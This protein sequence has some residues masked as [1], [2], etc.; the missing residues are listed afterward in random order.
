M[1]PWLIGLA[2]AGG[3]ARLLPHPPNVAPVA[4]LALFGGAC[5]SRLWMAVLVTL[6]SMI[7]S[8][9]VLYATV[10]RSFVESAAGIA[11][12]VLPVYGAFLLTIVVGRWLCRPRTWPRIASASVA[13][14][15]LFFVITNF[16]VWYGSRAYP[17]TWAGLWACYVAALPFLRNSL[18]GDLF[19]TV[20]LFGLAEAVSIGGR[21]GAAGSARA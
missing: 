3:L 13:A 15:L 10:Y 8:D 7:F 21:T 2:F 1:L 18:L 11:A 20:V 9:A 17:Q 16:F 6:G 12:S 19:F 5:F 4:A 14:S